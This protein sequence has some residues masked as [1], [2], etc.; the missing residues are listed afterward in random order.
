MVPA[1]PPYSRKN[2]TTQEPKRLITTVKTAA[3]NPMKKPSLNVRI[4]SSGTTNQFPAQTPAARVQQNS[5]G[6]RE[7]FILLAY[8][9]VPH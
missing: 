3:I 9:L 1:T 5:H 6:T 7:N 4:P 2:L 8:T